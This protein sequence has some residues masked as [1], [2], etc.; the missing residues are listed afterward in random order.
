MIDA[1]QRAVIGQVADE[2]DDLSY[3]AISRPTTRAAGARQL[4]ASIQ[5]VRTLRPPVA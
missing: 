5:V 3:A 4:S 1:R 2:S